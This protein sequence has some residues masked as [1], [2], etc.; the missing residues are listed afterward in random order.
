[1]D[2]VGAKTTLLSIP[3]PASCAAWEGESSAKETPL[4]RHREM[5]VVHS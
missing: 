5:D 3:R 1:M 2:A 4:F